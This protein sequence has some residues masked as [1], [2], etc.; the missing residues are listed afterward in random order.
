V[1]RSIVRLVV[2][3]A[4]V[5]VLLAGC[6]SGEKPTTAVP[7]DAEGVTLHP[8]EMLDLSRP[9]GT[10]EVALADPS[11]VKVEDT[12]Y[13]Y[14]TT[15]AEGFEMWSSTDL[16]RWTYGG[17]VWKPTVGTWN[18]KD[19]NGSGGYW[20]PEVHVNER[21]VWL[22]YTSNV[23][24]GVA[25]ADSPE[26]PFI[27]ALDHPLIGNGYGGVGDGDLPDSESTIVGN[28]DDRAWDAWLYEHSDGA[29]YL[30]FSAMTP[31]SE[32]RVIPLVD[33]VTPADVEPTVVVAAEGHLDTWEGW[34]REGPAVVEHEGVLHLTYSGNSWSNDCYSVGV[35]TA[36]DPLGPFTRD[37]SNPI[38]ATD[39]DS[40]FYAPGHNSLV[41]GPNGELLAFLHVKVDDVLFGE[42]R[43]MYAP[44]SFDDGA[45]RFVDPPSTTP[46]NTKLC[47][48][49]TL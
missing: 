2:V 19:P 18:E 24:I 40:E 13:L 21:G 44:V 33:E 10:D 36:T 1:T 28:F 26:G 47:L 15:D 38:I 45:L 46:P 25:R 22:Y 7:G 9:D 31:F 20:A 35:A 23:R 43:P 27:D 12:W 8:Y 37:D 3:A 5:A 11:V 17:V 30:Y 6:S 34:V 16:E 48:E 29:Q 39:A 41:E 4:T 42:R 14:G 32:M 49:P